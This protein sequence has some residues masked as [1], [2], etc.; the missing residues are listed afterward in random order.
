[1][2]TEKKYSKK[3]R[4]F[5]E[6][7]MSQNLI[8]LSSE[9]RELENK[10]E[11][12]I[13]EAYEHGKSESGD[14]LTSKEK[15]YRET[16][17]QKHLYWLIDQLEEYAAPG[18][19]EI[20][21]KKMFDGLRKAADEVVQEEGSLEQKTDYGREYDL[22]GSGYFVHLLNQPLIDFNI[23]DAIVMS[24]VMGAAGFI[25]FVLLKL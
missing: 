22:P 8:R 10:F 12:A 20:Q 18:H 24:I 3:Q 7:Y 4:E 11:A 9:A 19:A 13:S 23:L 14:V 6:L 1:M 16:E 5:I 17:K 25:I 21:N 2:Q 15:T